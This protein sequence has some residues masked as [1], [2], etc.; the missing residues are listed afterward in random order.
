MTDE[1]LRVFQIPIVRRWSNCLC[2]V[3]GNP[4]AAFT[5]DAHYG[6]HVLKA[7]EATPETTEPK[8]GDI[9]IWYGEGTEFHFALQTEEDCIITQH[10]KNGMY[11]AY[12]NEL[13]LKLGNYWFKKYKRVASIDIPLV[14]DDERRKEGLALEQFLSHEENYHY[15]P[16]IVKAMHKDFYR[17]R[18]LSNWWYDTKER[19][20]N[21][22]R[23][24]VLL[25]LESYFNPNRNFLIKNIKFH[26][27]ITNILG[28]IDRMLC[29]IFGI[30]EPVKEK[31]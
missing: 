29:K 12:P 2:F 1:L 28:D 21:T 16:K 15:I 13:G 23:D 27:I 20:V 17:G 7:I 19:I 4:I 22:W 31:K 18:R 26:Y 25:D 30:D 8:V 24:I 10:G 9:H 6:E 3:L 11:R 5:R 14:G